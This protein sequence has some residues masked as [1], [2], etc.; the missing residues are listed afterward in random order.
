MASKDQFKQQNTESALLELTDDRP[1]RRIGMLVLISTLVFF[2]GWAYLA[3]IDSASIAPGFLVVKSHKRTIQHLDGG[4]VSELLVKDGDVVKEGDLLLIL[5]GTENKAMLE[6]ARGQYIGLAAQAARL[7]A[8][9]NNKAVISY[10]DIF[11]NTGDSRI[12]E[13]KQSEEHLFRARK[14]AKNAEIDI[15]KQ[16]IGQLQSKIEGLKGMRKSKQELVVLYAEESKNLKELLSEGFVDKQ[17]IQEIERTHVSNQ[18]DIASIDS[19]IAGDEIQ[20]G[21]TKLKILQIE[22]KFQEDVN[23]RLSEAQAS[24]FEANQR[25]L[26]SRDKVNRIEIKAPV[27]GRV[28]GL[29]IHTLGG[30]IAPGSPILEIVPEHEELV[31]DAQVPMQDI[32][33]VSVGMIA[34]VHLSVFKQSQTPIT[35]GRVTTI[36]AD[37]VVNEKTQESYYS[38]E[39]ELTPESL[40]KLTNLKLVPGMPVEVMIKTGERTLFQYLTQPLSNAFAR[41]FTED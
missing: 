20:I 19:E 25:M 23:T 6:M 15:L 4:I 41:A 39:V 32:D 17:R 31:I 18:G 38:A 30:V 24:L 16:Q 37:R 5:D 12:V 8:E 29:A 2:G 36:S 3:P 26:A 14:N 13:A 27:A 34:E 22:K 21:E 10:P 1:I 9:R 35:E 28:M 40:S 33:R 11:K 7:E